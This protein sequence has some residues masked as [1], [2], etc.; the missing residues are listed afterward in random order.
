MIHRLR[1]Q[2]ISVAMLSLFL[3]FLVIVSTVS[4]L[5]YRSMASEADNILRILAENGGHF[6][7][8]ESAELQALLKKSPEVLFTCRYFFVVM[9]DSETAVSSNTEKISAVDETGAIEYAQTVWKHERGYC[10]D[11]RFIRRSSG[12]EMLFVFLDQSKESVQN[13]RKAKRS[14]YDGVL[15]IGVDG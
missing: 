2:L 10:W 11:F 4:A 14:A 15:L 1:R 5:N 13:G 6:P 8:W 3:V 9:A 12:D 7:D